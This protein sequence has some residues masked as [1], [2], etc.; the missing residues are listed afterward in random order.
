VVLSIAK[1]RDS[2]ACGAWL[3]GGGFVKNAL[4]FFAEINRGVF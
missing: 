3:R 2:R 4:P 1:A